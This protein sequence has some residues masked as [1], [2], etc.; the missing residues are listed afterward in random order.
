MGPLAYWPPLAHTLVLL[1]LTAVCLTRLGGISALPDPGGVPAV[2]VAEA[3][4]DVDL[5]MVPEVGVYTT[6]LPDMDARPLFMA[7][8]QPAALNGDLAPV[9]PAETTDPQSPRADLNLQMLAVIGQGETRRALVLADDAEVWVQEGD[10]LAGWQVVQIAPR[11]LVLE[12]G[13]QTA[14]FEMF[15]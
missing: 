3:S 13:D 6:V 12:L 10:D 15:D 5:D 1:A 7:G 8:R 14:I 4:A 11:S 2:Q 9:R